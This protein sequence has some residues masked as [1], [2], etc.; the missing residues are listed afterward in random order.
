M[1]WFNK[2]ILAYT[3]SVVKPFLLCKKTIPFASVDVIC[4]LTVSECFISMYTLSVIGMYS[5]AARCLQKA[6]QAQRAKQAREP[7]YLV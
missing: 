3:Y 4:V 1:Q 2:G 6:L 7:S 5:R